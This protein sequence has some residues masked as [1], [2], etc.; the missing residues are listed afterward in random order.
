MM[1]VYNMP[2]TEAIL[3]V[4]GRRRL[5]LFGWRLRHDGAHNERYS[6]RTDPLGRRV[7]P[8][9]QSR[10]SQIHAEPHLESLLIPVIS[11]DHHRRGRLGH[12]RLPPTRNTVRV[13]ILRRVKPLL[14]FMEL[15]KSVGQPENTR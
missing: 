3:A 4:R 12:T 7:P 2:R 10:L 9:C 1:L 13:S 6:S 14:R 11:Q 15:A 5:G 8:R